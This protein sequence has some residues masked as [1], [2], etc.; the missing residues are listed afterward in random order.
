MREA[1][2]RTY[3]GSLPPSRNEFRYCS[4]VALWQCLKEITAAGLSGILTRFPFIA[5]T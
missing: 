3:S 1:G 2:L 5:L 4:P